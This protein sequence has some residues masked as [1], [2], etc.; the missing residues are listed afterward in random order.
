MLDPFD[1]AGAVAL[2]RPVRVLR[3][4]IAGTRSV[5]PLGAFDREFR[6]DAGLTVLVADN[7]RGKTSVLELI[8]WCLRGT[9]RAGLQGVVRSWLSTVECDALVAG[10]PLEFRLRLRGGTLV[11][12]RVVSADTELVHATDETSYGERVAALMMELLHLEPLES[13]SSRSASGR[14]TYGWPSYFGA[15]YLPAGREPA[16]LGDDV[17]GGMPGRLLQVFLDLPGAA[18]LTRLKAFR[19]SVVSA[20]RAAAADAQRLRDLMARKRAEADRRLTDA[21]AA[22]AE[23]DGKEPVALSTV[24]DDITRLSRAVVAAEAESRDA[25][26]TFDLIKRQRQHDEM[27][28]ADLR[29]H[30][31]ARQLFYALDPAACPRCEAPVTDERRAA[32]KRHATCA[33][34][35]RPLGARDHADDQEVERE[36]HYRLT[37]SRD[38]EKLAR[39]NADDHVRRAARLRDALA[40]A[41]RRLTDADG[42]A[43]MAARSDLAREVA[44]WEGSVAALDST[45]IPG[46]PTH[47]TEQSVLDAAIDALEAGRNAASERLF[48]ELDRRIADLARRFG[49]RDLERVQIDKQARL[50]VFKTGGPVENFSGQSPGERLRLR[51]AVVVALLQV[52]HGHGNAS[53]PGF[54]MIDSP[55]AEEVQDADAAALLHALE[56]LCAETPDLQILVTTADEG[57][58][59]RTLSE[60]T[61]IAPPAPGAPLW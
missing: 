16:L 3:L 40:D 36:A 20:A 54:L 4:R 22:L 60:A 14:N 38:A 18:V 7:L 58:V 31:A 28:L 1:R 8:T 12:G 33:V 5:E 32:E 19:D 21:R 13:Q 53:H 6:L 9:P 17:M 45:A 34:C 43:R 24:V 49:F 55:C 52:G 35:A 48:D 51:I 61:V 10:R 2:P 59:R 30:D 26:K 56:R 37:A 41:E 25:L 27:R 42:A 29:E 57:L 39:D 23:L 46:A 47:P 50:K 11:E 15:M 44:R